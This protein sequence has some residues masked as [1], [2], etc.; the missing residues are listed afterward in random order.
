MSA[1]AGRY[2]VPSTESDQANPSTASAAVRTEDLYVVYL[3]DRTGRLPDRDEFWRALFGV[4][5][6]LDARPYRKR[7]TEEERE[8]LDNAPGP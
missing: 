5:G 4:E 1:F 2:S 3:L 6:P 7:L 8:Q